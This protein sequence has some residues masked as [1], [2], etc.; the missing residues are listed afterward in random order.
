MLQRTVSGS[1]D[2][3]L[4]QG[5][6]HEATGV[7]LIEA[8]VLGQDDGGD[9]GC[10]AEEDCDRDILHPA[11]FQAA[12]EVGT[13]LVADGE[14][15]EAEGDGVDQAQVV[16]SV[17]EDSPEP[18]SC[19]DPTPNACGEECEARILWKKVW[20]AAANEMKRISIAS[21]I[22]EGESLKKNQEIVGH[23]ENVPCR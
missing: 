12:D 17:V 10:D 3:G 7:S 4:G 16:I 1:D 8:E 20:E 22:A 15:E 2:C 21:L 23:S 18:V 13:D 11:T 14:D 6:A 19:L 5:T 9:Q